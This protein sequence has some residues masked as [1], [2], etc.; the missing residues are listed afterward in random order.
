MNTPD[1]L[2]I[3]H[4]P[5]LMESVQVDSLEEVVNSFPYFQAAR[6]LYLKGLKNQNSFRYNLNLKNTAAHTTDRSVLFHFITSDTFLD[7]LAQK[8]ESDFIESIELVD[9]QVIEN[10][11][12]QVNKTNI[13]EENDRLI[14][15]TKKIDKEENKVFYFE[16]D[17]K[18]KID[19]ELID[20][21][22][23]TD[24]NFD[25]DFSINFEPTTESIESE[26]PAST[27][28]PEEI[29]SESTDAVTET[30]KSILD[31]PEKKAEA[32]VTEILLKAA[33][34]K[35]E[36]KPAHFHKG[37]MHSF[38]EWLQL[39]SFKPI[40]RSKEPNIDLDKAKKQDLI[41]RFIISN[42]KISKIS[43]E[44]VNKELEATDEL[45]T[46]AIMT[47]TLAHLYEQQ[48]KY[49]SAI[50]AYEILGLKFPEKSSFFADQIERL[51]KLSKK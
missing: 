4:Q 8:K 6:V 51:K 30:T 23:Y 12:K 17:K 47:E 13:E 33:T 22:N 37:E 28:E 29:I 42:P 25:M 14:S 45:E 3:L 27:E 50:K 11:E 40:D 16:I 36:H 41:D 15:E 43:D 38:M 46:D 48:K 39:S 18:E 24:D 19:E 10:I 9:L 34:E 49:D 21:A 32:T 2:K 26:I 20:L 5:E 44:P 7:N 1:F 35:D 31:I